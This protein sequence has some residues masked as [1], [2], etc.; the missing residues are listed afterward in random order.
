[1]RWVSVQSAVDASTVLVVWY[2]VAI[3]LSYG[4]ENRQGQTWLLMLLPAFEHIALVIWISFL[5]KRLIG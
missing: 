5:E 1:M 4:E 3:T 2:R